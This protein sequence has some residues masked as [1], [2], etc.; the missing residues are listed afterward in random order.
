MGRFGLDDS[1][2]CPGC[3]VTSEDLFHCP[4][5]VDKMAEDLNDTVDIIAG[6][7]NVVVEMLRSELNCDI[8]KTPRTGLTPKMAGKWP[9]KWGWL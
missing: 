4:R 5:F 2:D 1:S 8:R 6:P 3:A 9:E 7:Y